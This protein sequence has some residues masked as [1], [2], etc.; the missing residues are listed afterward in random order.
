MTLPNIGWLER[1]GLET[2]WGGDR[3]RFA[4]WFAEQD[5]LRHLGDALGFRFAPAA[6]TLAP[7]RSRAGLVC[8]DEDSGAAV[9]VE[10]QLGVSRHDCFG[11]LMVRGTES[12]ADV[13]IWLA[14]RFIP[15]HRF[16]AQSLNCEALGFF[17]VEIGL[18][19]I[20]DSPPALHFDPV[21]WPEDWRGPRRN[22]AA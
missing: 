2:L 10:A 1:V 9:A 8:R 19:Q 5:R 13:W 12:K 21:A 7:G 6:G 3:S 14:E 22:R 15:E 16:A 17:A 20:G 4:F 18:W 11:G